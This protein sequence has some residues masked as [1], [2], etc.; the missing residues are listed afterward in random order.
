[1]VFIG[2][3]KAKLTSLFLEILYDMTKG[4]KYSR[5]FQG[6]LVITALGLMTGCALIPK[7]TLSAEDSKPEVSVNWEALK[8]TSSVATPVRWWTLF[9]DDVLSSLK[10]EQRKIT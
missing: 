10:V 2:S 1:M 7:S 5:W 3:F 6:G 8:T 4:L 9:H